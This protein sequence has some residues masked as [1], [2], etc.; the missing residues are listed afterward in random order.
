MVQCSG[1]YSCICPS[2]NFSISHEFSCRTL[3]VLKADPFFIHLLRTTNEN[4]SAFPLPT[5]YRSTF[6]LS[7]A[8]V[9]GCQGYMLSY[10]VCH[11]VATTYICYRSKLK[12][13]NLGW[14]SIFFTSLWPSPDYSGI[15]ARRQKKIEKQ[16]TGR[17]KNFNLNLILTCFTS[18]CSI[19]TTTVTLF[20]P[21]IIT[22]NIADL[23]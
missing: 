19:T 21:N 6:A 12:F 15:W 2:L 11:W 3:A 14:F 23:I 20:A 10:N 17:L 16:L 22:D 1:V 18:I 8:V 13:F 7:S 9:F 5:A 4:C